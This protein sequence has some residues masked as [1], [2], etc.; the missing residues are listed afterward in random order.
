MMRLGQEEITLLF[1]ISFVKTGHALPCLDSP[2]PQL[3]E[4]TGR[5]DSPYGEERISPIY[6]YKPFWLHA[7]KVC[8]DIRFQRFFG[9]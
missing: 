7:S 9:I 2:N 3:S 5:N 8:S 6:F 4:G 1:R